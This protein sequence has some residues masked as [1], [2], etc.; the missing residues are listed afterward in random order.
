MSINLNKYSNCFTKAKM[1]LSLIP[2]CVL[3]S[4]AIPLKQSIT[5]EHIIYIQPLGNVDS[6]CLNYLKKSV[7]DFYGY[8]CSIKT[9]L[10]LTND[11]LSNSKTRYDANKILDKYNSNINLLLITEKDIA[12][13]KSNQFPEWGIF[14]L[15]LR[16]GQ[17]CVVSTFRL[18]RKVSKAQMLIRLK[19]VAL[20]EIGHN[21]GLSHCKNNKECMMSN[22]DG[23]IKQVDREKIWFC[24]KCWEQLK[25]LN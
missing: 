10:E 15:G 24:E 11:L 14:G 2:L 18:K 21:L 4:T 1:M 17:T 12:H 22:A 8:K 20:H 9:K 19:K 25:R 5:K 16:P 3:I 6:E 7:E 13:K 23:T